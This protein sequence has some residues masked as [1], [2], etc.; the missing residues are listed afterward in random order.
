MRSASLQW[1]HDLA[2][3]EIRPGLRISIALLICFNGA[4]TSRSWKSAH[5]A[6]ALPHTRE[7]QWSH[8]LAVVE[9]PQLAA[10][11]RA[12]NLLQWS[13]DLAVVEI[14]AKQRNKKS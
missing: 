5:T 7:L 14:S 13:H 1:S 12:W 10:Y 8:D 11:E 9:M 3:V 2:V 6:F 4:T